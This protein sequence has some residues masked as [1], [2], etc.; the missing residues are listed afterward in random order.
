MSRVISWFSCGAASAVATILAIKE[1]KD[2]VPVYC[3]TGGEHEDNVRF[4]ADCEKWF[5][6]TIT[7]LRSE[8]YEDV[9]DVWEK[10]RWLSGINGAR[11]TT[12]LKVKPRLGFQ[13]PTDLHVFGYTADRGDLD[14]ADRLRE[15]YPELRILTPLID[16]GLTKE[17]V[18]SIVMSA[19][20]KLP[21]PYILGFHNNNCK[22]CVKA[23][24]PDYWA[25]VRKCYPD[26]FDRMAKLSRSLDVKLCRIKGDRSFIDEIPLDH[27]MVDP[28][29]PSCDFLCHIIEE[30][31]ERADLM[32]KKNG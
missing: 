29:A 1:H 19:G 10:T 11:C 25:L 21:E 9:W 22:T 18:L 12:E 28:I 6:K 7:R 2:V 8:E 27:P 13:K 4:M 5:G 3:E 16:A 23:T 32:E 14:R 20:I 26:E 15:N 24:S 31:L 17:H 30:D